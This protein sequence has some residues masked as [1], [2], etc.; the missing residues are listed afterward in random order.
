VIKGGAF[1]LLCACVFAIASHAIGAPQGGPLP[2]TDLALTV[3]DAPDPVGVFPFGELIYTAT[4]TNLGPETAVGVRFS[5]AVAPYHTYL[6]VV[7]PPGCNLIFG[8]DGVECDYPE[9]AAGGSVTIIVQGSVSQ[10]APAALSGTASVT[11]QNPDPSPGNNAVSVVTTVRPVVSMASCIGFPEGDSGPN[12]APCPAFLIGPHEQPVV[13]GYTLEGVTAT[14]GL[15]FVAASGTLTFPAQ[16]GE[17]EASVPIIYLG[18]TLPEGSEAFFVRLTSVDAL[19]QPSS[20]PLW[21]WDD[22]PWPVEAELAHGSM[23]RSDLSPR[24]AS[25]GVDFMLAR[26]DEPGTS[27]EAVVDEVSGKA[28]PVWLVKDSRFAEPVGTGSARSL[29]WIYPEPYPIGP[30]TVYVGSNGCASGCG[31]GD[32]YRLR[33][34][35]TT[36]T[37][38]V[39]DEKPSVLIL[40]NPRDEPVTVRVMYHQEP[41]DGFVAELAPRGSLVRT[42]PTGPRLVTVGHDAPYGTLVGKLVSIDPETGFVS[43]SILASRPR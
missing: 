6:G 17:L 41:N 19:V 7:P 20:D 2:A 11:A 35:E 34:Y 30:T 13:V 8:N 40:Q 12:R 43:E 4:V 5:L 21:I 16:P 29:R 3:T 39:A 18:D 31:P 14:A 23:R 10:A 9:V 32:R 38:G 28:E 42:L 24:A 15:D 27:Y 22:D 33:F 37:G 1:G 25:T 26:A 36:L